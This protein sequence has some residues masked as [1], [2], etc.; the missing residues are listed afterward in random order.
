MLNHYFNENLHKGRNGLTN[1]DLRNKAWKDKETG[2]PIVALDDISSV[3][4]RQIHIHPYSREDTRIC[5]GLLQS[6]PQ[7]LRRQNLPPGC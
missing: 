7:A 3:V 5:P 6:G 2:R 1:K 4:H